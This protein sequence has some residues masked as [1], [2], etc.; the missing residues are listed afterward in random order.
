MSYLNV[1]RLVFFGQ[2]QASISTINNEPLHFNNKTFKPE[3]QN[4]QTGDEPDQL[5]GWFNPGG[6]GAWRLIGCKVTSAWR[7]DGSAVGREDPILKY[8]IA[9]SDRKVTAKLVD[10]DPEQQTVSEIWG[11][12]VRICDPK[13]KTLLR[14]QFKPAPFMDIWA[15]YP[16][17]GGDEAAGA[18]YQSVLADLEW[19][20][21][22]KS[23]VLQ[24]L[25]KAAQDGLLSIKFNV[26]GLSADFTK[27]DKFLRGRIV[28]SIGPATADEPHH[29]VLGRQFMATQPPNNQ[30]FFQ[31]TGQINFCVALL[32]EVTR[33]LY[34]DLGNALPVQDAGSDFTDIGKLSLV[35]EVPDAQG[36][37]HA[38]TIGTIP[39]TDPGWYER[40]AGI[41]EF[42]VETLLKDVQENP[43]ALV[44]TQ[45]NGGATV[46]IPEAFVYVRADQ[47]VF[48]L[49]PNEAVEV[50][51]YATR[52]GRPYAGARVLLAFDPSQLQPQ[53]TLGLAPHV[54]TPEPAIDFPGRLVADEKGKASFYIRASDPGNPRG[55]IDGQVYGVRPALEETLF[56]NY[57]ANPS[58]YI[59]VL[60]WD[61]FE[62][63]EPLTWWPR[64]QPIFQQYANL[65]P[66]MKRF[67]DLSD[68]DSVCQNRELLEL[69]F[70]LDPHDPN[71]MPATRDL[72][73]AKR[74]AILR[75][76][77]DPLL[78][79]PPKKSAAAATAGPPASQHK[80][81][82]KGGKALAM[83]RRLVVRRG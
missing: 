18:M 26:D 44:L 11:L 54:G 61:R 59:S 60:V 12:E 34:L 38:H 50:H 81:L 67:L 37:M 72:S 39:Y 14:G 35:Y 21:I 30:G 15:R 33:K 6:D 65:Y 75:W 43:L 23:G 24:D 79:T 64:I 80:R 27:P 62:P 83:S 8:L 66:V 63:E 68:Y 51:L 2:F 49:N 53:S 77:N 45:T 5:N 4:R 32:D 16:Q 9:D 28:G 13:G 78:G 82:P 70:G 69:A 22:S 46:A 17:G 71:S 76:L 7:A 73:A 3:F 42:P 48:R 1:P 19:G 58:N 55:Y 29:F 57:P 47:F 41:I 31:P 20:D 74:A 10:L 36:N 56:G 25:Q 40:T 52:L